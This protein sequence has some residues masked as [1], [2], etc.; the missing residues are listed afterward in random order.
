MSMLTFD[1]ETEGKPIILYPL[2][3]RRSPLT[4]LGLYIT[5]CIG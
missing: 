2:L 4:A 3:M 5:T 1:I